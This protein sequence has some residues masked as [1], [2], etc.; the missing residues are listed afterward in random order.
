MKRVRGKAGFTLIEVILV[1]VIAGI[2][3]TVALRS[4]SVI[5]DTARTEETK[6]EMEKLAIAIAG[7]PNIHTNG[8]RS[9][10]GYIGDVGALPAD[11][12]ALVANPGFAT[13][14]GPYIASPLAQSGDDFKVDTWGA[15]YQRTGIDLVS[16][17]SGSPIVRPLAASEDALLRNSVAGVIL[18]ADGTPPGSVYAD[19]LLV[20]LTY[21][22]GGGGVMVRSGHPD[23]GGYFGF[24]SIPIGHHDIGVIYQADNDTLTRFVCVTPGASLYSE[25]ILGVDLWSATGGGGG[26][27][28]LTFVAGSDTLTSGQCNILNFRIVNDAA[29]PV[30]ISEMS[31]AWSFPTAYYRTILWDGVQVYQN[32]PLTS[33]DV[34]TFTSAQTLGAGDTV[35]ITVQQFKE[36]SNGGGPSI[37][38][39]GVGF[40]VTFS[41]GSVMTF[42][43]DECD[44]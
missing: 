25:Y 10:F 38:M 33:G 19:S 13:W 35:E 9:D 43:A 42:T 6:R 4:V 32:P 29:N 27:T 24:D 30:T 15:A 41:D 8:V 16:N 1:V 11:F 17:G 3:A 2:L 40:T 7:D 18:D 28:G 39:T 22:N 34:A 37:D 36:F 44:R 21:P 14:K 12:D 31:L 5:G 23:V 20:V 26:G